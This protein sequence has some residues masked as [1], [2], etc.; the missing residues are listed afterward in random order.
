MTLQKMANGL[1]L[2]KPDVDS[3]ARSSV[4]YWLTVKPHALILGHS[5]N[6]GRVAV[7][8]TL[9]ENLDG[10][11]RWYVRYMMQFDQD[12]HQEGTQSERKVIAVVP[13]NAAEFV[14]ANWQ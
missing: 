7:D 10:N 2:P 13:V 5:L 3:N 8:K 4:R 11:E 14:L 12:L 1:P 6:S 9:W